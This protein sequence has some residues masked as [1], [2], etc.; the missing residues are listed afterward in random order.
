LFAAAPE[1][2]FTGWRAHGAMPRRVA[3]YLPALAWAG[4]IALAAGAT[5]MPRTPAVPHVDK[6]L[7]FGAYFV[8]G[9]LLGAGWHWA[10][11]R[12]ARGWLLLFAL[13]L[14]VSDEVRQSRMDERT[15]EVADWVADAVGATAGL[16]LTARLLG[17]RRTNH[18]DDD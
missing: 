6:V 8:L 13:V 7:H 14:G 17:R 15:G 18:G 16:F 2:I 12:P 9:A 3:A 5:H 11:R 1:D 10:G 4:L